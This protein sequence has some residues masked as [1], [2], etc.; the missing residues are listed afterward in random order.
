MILPTKALALP[1][2]KKSSAWAIIWQRCT[3]YYSCTPSLTG[4]LLDY[5]Y[6]RPTRPRSIASTK[7]SVP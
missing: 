5:S 3:T 2:K 1:S 4:S 7:I 6:L